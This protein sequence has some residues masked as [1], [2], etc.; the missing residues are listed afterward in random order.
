MCALLDDGSRLDWVGSRWRALT[1]TQR[2]TEAGG[3]AEVG[4]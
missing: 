1:G 2:L 3:V 4:K